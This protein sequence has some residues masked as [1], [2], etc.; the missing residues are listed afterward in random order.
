MTEQTHKILFVPDAAQ[1]PLGIGSLEPFIVE[2]AVV[3]LMALRKK[4]QATVI[5]ALL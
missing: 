5:R 2:E 1:L 4:Y 3:I